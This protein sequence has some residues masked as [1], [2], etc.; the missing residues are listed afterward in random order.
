MSKQE[1]LRAWR[2]L[3]PLGGALTVLLAGCAT[4]RMRLRLGTRGRREH[5]FFYRLRVD[6]YS[7]DGSGSLRLLPEVYR[8]LCEASTEC[9]RIQAQADAKCEPLLVW[10]VEPLGISR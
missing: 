1:R 4:P 8:E 2:S 9:A 7:A 6:R 5:V 10:V 3:L